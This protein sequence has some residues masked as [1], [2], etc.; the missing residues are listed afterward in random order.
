M[1]LS[2]LAQLIG[3]IHG[4]LHRLSASPV[5]QIGLTPE[6]LK[7]Y[8]Q[9]AKEREP[10]FTGAIKRLLELEETF[11]FGSPLTILVARSVRLAPD[12]ELDHSEWQVQFQVAQGPS[13][14][15]K[16]VEHQIEAA[17]FELESY[18][19]D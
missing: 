4:V 10:K 12:G 19:F 13:F 17:R 18:I 3:P 7:S 1:E 5:E 2:Q 15:P 14:D 11:E 16:V 9:V 8:F 6:R